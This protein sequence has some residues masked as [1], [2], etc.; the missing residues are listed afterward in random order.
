M[1]MIIL[2]LYLALSVALVIWMFRADDPMPMLI[3]LLVGILGIIG[4]GLC[5]EFH[6][7]KFPGGYV[8]MILTIIWSTALC[9]LG[10]VY[11]LKH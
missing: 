6:Y 1:E 5:M 8:G 7:D 3:M 10:S 9:S 2:C 4:V 11:V